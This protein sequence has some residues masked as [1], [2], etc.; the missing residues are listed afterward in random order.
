MVHGPKWPFILCEAR[1][2]KVLQTSGYGQRLGNASISKRAEARTRL[3]GSSRGHGWKV[4]RWS[5][6]LVLLVRLGCDEPDGL[7]G[8]RPVRVDQW[9]A[10]GL[11]VDVGLGD[12]GVWEVVVGDLEV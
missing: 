11:Y 2:T 8:V 6:S 4:H 5:W 1:I 10:V 9:W 12:L 7:L 3:E